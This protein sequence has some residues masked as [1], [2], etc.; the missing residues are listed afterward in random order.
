MI[1]D[2]AGGGLAI[3]LALWLR[4]HHY[5]LSPSKAISISPWLDLTHSFPSFKANAVYDW[6]P[7]AIKDPTYIKPGRSHLYVT[8]NSLLRHPYVS[9]VFATVNDQRPLKSIYIQVGELERLRDESI[10]FAGR[11]QGVDLDIIK[12]GIHV[13]SLDEK[14]IR[15]WYFQ[16]ENS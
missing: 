8:D 12:D 16:R 9:P 10:E 7:E 6:L 1:G 2:S 14:K 15:D 13:L 3:G 5:E 11:H 4:D